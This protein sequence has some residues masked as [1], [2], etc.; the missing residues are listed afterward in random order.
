VLFEFNAHAE[1][2]INTDERRYLVSAR[3]EPELNGVF[4]PRH[5]RRRPGSQKVSRTKV[6]LRESAEVY[7]RTLLLSNSGYGGP[8]L[9]GV[10]SARKKSGMELYRS[11]VP[12][13]ALNDTQGRVFAD[14]ALDSLKKHPQRG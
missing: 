8:G 2:P 10:R 1:T 14:L 11:R 6:C 4:A 3:N 13:T 9:R 5:F 12:A 7:R